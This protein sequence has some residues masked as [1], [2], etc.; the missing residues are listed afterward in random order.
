[1]FATL[2]HW[3]EPSDVIMGSWNSWSRVIPC[4]HQSELPFYSGPSTP[5]WLY[6]TAG[7]VETSIVTL[8][9][10]GVTWYWAIEGH[11]NFSGVRD[12]L[13]LLWW[14]SLLLQ[15][16][17]VCS[18]GVQFENSEQLNI[19]QA[20]DSTTW[21]NAEWGADTNHKHSTGLV[22]FIIKWK[23]FISENQSFPFLT[24]RFL[25]LDLE[26][27]ELTECPVPVNHQCLVKSFQRYALSNDWDHV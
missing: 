23:V 9:L 15:C 1:M 5:R 11:H 25:E 26:Q 14:Y 27:T 8:V 6:L 24:K 17:T 10:R 22:T 18:Q 4:N 12:N 2:R 19:Q 16:V 21:C 13:G 7:G 3:A 20:M